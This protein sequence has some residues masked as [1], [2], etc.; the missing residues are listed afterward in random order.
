[1]ARAYNLPSY[2]L[3]DTVSDVNM[4]RENNHFRDNAQKINSV[5]ASFG[6]KAMV[7]GGDFGPMITTYK[8]SYAPG[9]SINKIKGCLANISY[10]LGTSNARFA[11]PKP[12]QDFI[13]LEIPNLQNQTV[14]LRN[15]GGSFGGTSLISFGLGTSASCGI[16]CDLAKMPHLLIAGATG[17]GKS[18][19]INSIITSILLN[20]HPEFVKFMMIDPK[21]VELSQYNGIPHLCAPVVTDPVKAVAWLRGM[22]DEMDRRYN[23][24]SENGVRNIES[25]NQVYRDAQFP[26]IVVVIDELADLMY[27]SGKKAEAPIVR[28]AQL[29][30]AA[31]IHLVIATQRPTRD[32]ITGLI[33]ANMPSR[34]AFATASAVD[35][36]TILDFGGAEKLLGRGDMLYKPADALKPI[37]VQGVYVSDGEVERVVNAVKMNWFGKIET[38]RK[39]GFFE[40]LF[41]KIA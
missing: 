33:K 2:D 28:L 37:R 12:G 25:Y 27:T 31:G 1:M 22:C 5:F 17:S 14:N 10:A 30:R 9:V 32:V 36:R 4:D 29:G 26:R 24:M 8:I 41:G 11:D 34:I 39:P 3:L 16:V 38:P 20:A 18:V 19:C 6:V 13:G 23:V 40:K 15:F 21:Q 35:S 7:M